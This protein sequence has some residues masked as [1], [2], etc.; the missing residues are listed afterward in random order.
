MTANDVLFPINLPMDLEKCGPSPCAGLKRPNHHSWRSLYCELVLL[1]LLAMSALDSL[2]GLD[3]SNVPYIPPPPG[4]VSDLAMPGALTETTISMSIVLLILVLTF[5]LA[6]LYAT[7]AVTR[8]VGADDL[9]IS[10]ACI[11]GAT[12]TALTLS[13]SA[14]ARHPWDFALSMYTSRIA[15]IIYAEQMTMAMALFLSKLSILILFHRLFSVHRPFCYA[16][17]LGMIIYRHRFNH[18][19]RSLLH[20]WAYAVFQR[21]RS[22]FPL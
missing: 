20:T 10:I 15:K 4:K 21:P 16:N 11:F 7:I 1:F 12:T 18:L 13:S 5:V 6:R 2:S 19:R 22:G 3:L 14:L 9:T 8:S 17:Y